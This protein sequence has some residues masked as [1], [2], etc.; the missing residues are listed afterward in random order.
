MLMRADDLEMLGLVLCTLIFHQP[1][2]WF[3]VVCRDVMW[4]QLVIIWRSQET[5]ERQMDARGVSS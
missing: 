1:L 3:R 4:Y 2:N 5:T